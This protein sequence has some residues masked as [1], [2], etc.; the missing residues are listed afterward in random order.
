MD[1]KIT[2]AVSAEFQ[3]IRPKLCGNCAF[4]QNFH[5]K[6]FAQAHYRRLE[7]IETMGNVNIT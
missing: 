7:S 2:H 6:N 3:V 5:T 4:Q 1:N